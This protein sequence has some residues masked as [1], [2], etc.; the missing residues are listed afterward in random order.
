MLN[1]VDELL[2]YLYFLFCTSLPCC[3]ILAQKDT[4]EVIVNMTSTG[5]LKR[6][7][8]LFSAIAIVVANMVGTGIFT[9]SGFILQEVGSSSALLLG[10]L[11]G[12]AFALCGALCYGELGARFPQA[13][14]EYIYLREAF[15]KPMA[16]L[17]GWVSLIV[18]FSAPIAAGAIAFA[19]YLLKALGLEGGNDH[20]LA[21]GGVTILT[22]SWP[23]AVAIGVVLVLS[24]LHIHSLRIGSRVQ[25]LLTLFKVALVV[26]FI[27]AG[28]FSSGGS[29]G[30]FTG[31]LSLGP[32]LDGKFAVAL[33][34][35]TFAYS[36]WNAAAY[37]GGEIKQPSRNI[38]LAL[39]VG[40]SVVMVLYLLLNIVYVYALPPD[41]MRG[42]ME[43]GAAAAERLFGQNMGR[44]L[45]AAI[46][47]GLVSVISAMILTGPRV[48]YAMSK[49]GIFFSS[50]GKVHAA[51]H[52]PT[53]AVGLQ[54]AIAM[55]M[56][57][58]AAYDKL[59]I[60]IGFTL[61]IFAM[62]TV[63][64]LMRLRRQ[65]QGWSKTVTYRT[66]G[67]PLTPLIFILGNLWI[68]Y[69]SLKSRPGPVLWGLATIA[70]GWVVYLYFSRRRLQ[71]DGLKTSRTS[72]AKTLL[73][74]RGEAGSPQP[75]KK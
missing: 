29:T 42:V 21:L 24:L 35:I 31:N 55:V 25:N 7:I 36:G 61:S 30:H 23:V 41:Q 28:L 19:I 49:D 57:V 14:G 37:L 46:A 34:F 13:G 70:A 10:W 75:M 74:N 40:T 65:R 20:V 26:V 52:T 11:V 43:V 45:S 50:F 44:W 48:Y 73:S 27:G 9:T 63:V 68:I 4:T 71:S 72:V 1:R 15:G 17:S 39:L 3:H 53:H 6:E 69:F 22:F 64:G 5:Q 60:Y 66:W 8:G 32:V 56:I 38:P 67:Y 47:L 2:S 59:L 33:I 51:R 18:G 58:T 62:L 12:G 54:A 16:F